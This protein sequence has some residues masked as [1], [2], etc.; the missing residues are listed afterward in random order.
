MTAAIASSRAMLSIV[1][2]DERMAP[3][4]RAYQTK[5]SVV[6]V[7]FDQEGKGRIVFLPYGATLRVVGPSSCLPEGLEVGFDM[8]LYNV[9]ETD[10][11]ERSTPI[12][13]SIPTRATAM[14]VCA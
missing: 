5:T 2:D 7:Y 13:E 4:P 8:Q 9:F 10:L 6:A 3:A 11:L 12:C 14:A 1:T